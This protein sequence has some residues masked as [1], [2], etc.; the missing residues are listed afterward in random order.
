MK[1]YK[2][3]KLVGDVDETECELDSWGGARITDGDNECKLG[4]VM[5]GKCKGYCVATDGDET[6]AYTI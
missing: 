6:Y 5:R 2:N 3:G 4:E 1:V